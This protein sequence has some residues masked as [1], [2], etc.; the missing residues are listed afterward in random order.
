MRPF[1]QAKKGGAMI[2]KMRDVCYFFL[3]V[4]LALIGLLLVVGF[5]ILVALAEKK[6]DDDIN[7]PNPNKRGDGC[8]NREPITPTERGGYHDGRWPV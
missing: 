5:C 4:P 1:L 7:G 6:P 2:L 8:G 3:C